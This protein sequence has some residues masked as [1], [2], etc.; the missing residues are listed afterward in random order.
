MR[1]NWNHPPVWRR[2]RAP[3][4][5]S[6]KKYAPVSLYSSS[7]SSSSL[8]RMV[9]TFLMMVEDAPSQ[10]RTYIPRKAVL[11]PGV[12]TIVGKI[13]APMTVPTMTSPSKSALLVAW[14]GFLVYLFSCVTPTKA[15]PTTAP[16]VANLLSSATSNT[17]KVVEGALRRLAVRWIRRGRNMNERGFMQ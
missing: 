12:H 5:N 9:C 15:P 16:K 2:Q 13:T 4:G 6:S 1:V 7:S 3:S 11:S 10:C 14:V 8:W 17:T